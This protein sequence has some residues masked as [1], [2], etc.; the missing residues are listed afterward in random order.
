MTRSNPNNKSSRLPPRSSTPKG[1]TER[2]KRKTS[3]SCGNKSPYLTRG[4]FFYEK[5][6]YKKRRRR[7]KKKKKKNTLS[8]RGTD[9]RGGGKKEPDHFY[10][11]KENLH[12]PLS[13]IENESKGRERE[14][15]R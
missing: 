12:E 11:M 10:C 15:D 8:W 13:R 14:R 9:E 7:K 2:R 6:S 3:Q 5:P 1:E 4:F